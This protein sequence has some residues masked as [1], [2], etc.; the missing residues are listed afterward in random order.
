[1]H[2]HHVFGYITGHPHGVLPTR[3]HVC[4][5]LGLFVQFELSYVSQEIP[6]LCL[7]QTST[8]EIDD[9]LMS[10]HPFKAPGVDGMTALFFPNILE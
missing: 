1:M 2:I 5:V 8:V 9:A 6:T 10:M 4:Q 3:A 7:L